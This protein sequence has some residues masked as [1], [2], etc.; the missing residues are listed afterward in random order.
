MLALVTVPVMVCVLALIPS[1]LLVD[2]SKWAQLVAMVVGPIELK[3]GQWVEI[4]IQTIYNPPTALETM[5]CFHEFS[6]LKTKTSSKDPP[7]RLLQIVTSEE[8]LA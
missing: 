4:P 3:S 5:A 7:K 6:S 1:V 2:H 8:K